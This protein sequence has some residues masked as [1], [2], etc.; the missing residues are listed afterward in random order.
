MS[1]RE[2]QET[3]DAAA[4]WVV[5]MHSDQVTSEDERLFSA[6]LGEDP[7]HGEAYDRQ[8][9]LWRS[10]AALRLDPA[11]MAGFAE[12]REPS[13][14][15]HRPTRRGLIAASLG[16][17]VALAGGWLAW[18]AAFGTHAYATEVGEQRRIVLDDGSSVTLNTDSALRVR[19]S[20][21]ERKLWLDKGQAY[22]SVVRDARRPFC[23]VVGDDE[24]RGVGSAFDVRREG[25][26]AKIIVEEGRAELHR[27]PAAGVVEGGVAAA[28]LRPGQ[29]LVLA[30]ASR[31]EI[32]AVDARS[33]GSWRFG[34]LVFDS[35]PLGE[36][37]A[38][39]NRY[40]ERQI[41]IAD[42]AL[43][44]L[45]INGVFQTGKPEAFVQ[46]LTAA[47]PVEV[48]SQDAGGIYLERR[49]PS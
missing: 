7:G 9:K 12:L 38:E 19:F 8:N 10:V 39:I 45:A 32:S 13:R 28:V 43:A 18:D 47:F 2:Q 40:N 11:A 30:P 37:V 31:V 5:R 35:E 27:K 25:D 44:D 3:E 1:Q 16:G 21:S 22:F 4:F 49:A 17:G 26:K 24:L 20:R 23:L 29:R 42:P 6:W 48:R 15:P 34:R 14:R 36:A 41:V 33:V 46:A